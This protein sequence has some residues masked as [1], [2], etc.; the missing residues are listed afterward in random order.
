LK[1]NFEQ[2]FNAP[3]LVEL[4]LAEI[5]TESEKDLLLRLHFDGSFQFQSGGVMVAASEAEP[6][7][8]AKKWLAAELAKKTARGEVADIMLQAWWCLT[9]GKPFGEAIP[10]EADRQAGWREATQGRV[11]EMG[12]LARKSPRLAKYEPLTLAQAGL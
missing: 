2:I 1:Q 5:G 7:A 11:V 8:A 12:W 10:S 6:E 9:K 3:F 4:L